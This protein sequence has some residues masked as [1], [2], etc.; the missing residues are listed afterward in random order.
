MAAI[1]LLLIAL[2]IIAAVYYF[3]I[4]LQFFGVKIY[5]FKNIS[6]FKAMI[7]YYYLIKYLRKSTF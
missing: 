5:P 1:R 7:P 2:I 4:A 6:F 3:S